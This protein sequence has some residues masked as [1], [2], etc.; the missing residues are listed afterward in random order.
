MSGETELGSDIGGVD[1]HEA[2]MPGVCESTER[3][4][5]GAGVEEVGPEYAPRGWDLDLQQ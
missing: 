5:L 1:A 2:S 3:A 4:A